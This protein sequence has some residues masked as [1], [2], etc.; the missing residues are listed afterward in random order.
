MADTRRMTGAL[1]SDEQLQR[2]G[3][4]TRD[5]SAASGSARKLA[6]GAESVVGRVQRGEGTVGA[7]L[8]DEAIYDDLQE[9]LRDLKHNPWKFFWRD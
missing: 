8:A 3:Q 7:L 5:V 2:Y 9:M 4:I 1:A 6:A